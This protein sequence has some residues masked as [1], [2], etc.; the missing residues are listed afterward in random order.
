M[1]TED[2]FVGLSPTVSQVIDQFVSYLHADD[3]IGNNAI[4]HLEK[5]IRKPSVPKPDEINAA[6]FDHS[7]DDEK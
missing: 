3:K 6:L 4:D 1:A 5:L 2:S 7:P